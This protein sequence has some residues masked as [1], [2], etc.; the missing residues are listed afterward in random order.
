M[1]KK[2]ADEETPIL[3]VEQELTMEEK[4][5]IMFQKQFDKCLSKGDFFL[6]IAVNSENLKELLMQFKDHIAARYNENGEDGEAIVAN[7]YPRTDPQILVDTTLENP[8]TFLTMGMAE[9]ESMHTLNMKCMEF[10]AVELAQRLGIPTVTVTD[11]DGKQYKTVPFL[12]DYGMF[13]QAIVTTTMG[14]MFADQLQKFNEKAASRIQT[15]SAVPDNV[16]KILK[17]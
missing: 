13:K 6:N 7:V 8:I 5:L 14:Y 3:D 17:G 12:Y 4:V 9:H 16:N 15:V 1:A 2:Q 11:Q 10:Y